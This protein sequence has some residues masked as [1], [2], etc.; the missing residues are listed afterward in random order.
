MYPW[1][2]SIPRSVAFT[3][4]AWL[5]TAFLAEPTSRDRLVSFYRKVHPAGPGWTTIRLE[6]GITEDQ[7]AL[8]GDHMGM[9][10][11]GWISGCLTI[12]S[13]LFAIGNFLYGR[14]SLALGLMAVFVVSG[15][16]LL[17]VV[18]HLWDRPTVRTA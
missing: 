15:G 7:A 5:I 9:A 14:S 17:W 16:T 10:T 13:S 3:T 4:V 1:K 18:R 2:N 12:W 6:A 8:Q 11:L